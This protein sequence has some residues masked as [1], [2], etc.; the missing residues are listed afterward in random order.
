MVMTRAPC[1]PTG[2]TQRSAGTPGD[3]AA[4]AAAMARPA[5]VASSE[6]PG[7]REHRRAGARQAAPEGAGGHRRLLDGVEAGHETGALRLGHV[8]LQRARQER[9]VARVQRRDQRAD[10]GPLAH[11][12]LQ[13]HGVAQQRARRAGVDLDGGMQHGTRQPGGHRQPHDVGRLD[14]ARQDEAAVER[15]R[16]VVGVD[17]AAA[18]LLAGHRAAQQQVEVGGPAQQLVHGHDGRHRAGAAAADAAGQRQALVQHERDALPGAERRQEGIGGGTGGVAAAVARQPAAVALHVGDHRAI[19]L[20]QGRR[21]DVAGLVERESEHVEAGGHVRHGAGRERRDHRPASA[22][23]TI[24]IGR[25]SSPTA[26]S[27]T[28]AS[29]TISHSPWPAPHRSTS[30]VTPTVTEVRPMRR[31]SV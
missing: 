18:G 30:T 10:V 15:R 28:S 12:G 26:T 22:A 6:R 27:T 3:A 14:A 16:D 2:E 11:R 20:D 31:V 5:A 17:G 9:Q 21:H 7:E 19:A 13:R 29:V 8:V 25:P 1:V 23:A 24:G 4:Q